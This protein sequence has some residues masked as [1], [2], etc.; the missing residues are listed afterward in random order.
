MNPQQL[1]KYRV[2]QVVRYKIPIRQREP[3]DFKVNVRIIQR[4]ER[5]GTHDA[6]ITPVSGIGET[7]VALGALEA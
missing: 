2:G 6:L 3:V 4:R 7:W 5:C 1:Y